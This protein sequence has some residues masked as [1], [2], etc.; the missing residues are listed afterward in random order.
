MKNGTT[1]KNKLLNLLKSSSIEY[2]KIVMEMFEANEK[3]IYPLDFFLLGIIK[4]SISLMSG[5]LL[6]MKNDNYLSA[7]PLVRLH[8]DNLLQ[9]YA[10]F[11][12]KD[13]HDIAT[14]IMRGKKR[15]REYY[16]KD[17]KKMSDNYLAKKFFSNKKNEEFIGLENVYNEASKFIHFSE[18]HIF[19]IISSIDSGRKNV[20][21]V[22]SD[23]VKI[24]IEKELEIIRCMIEI[25]KAQ[26]KYLIG[27][28]ETKK[29]NK[30]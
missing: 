6:L 24:P 30:C 9:I 2:D 12:V 19:S 23:E 3:N 27:W 26:F 17:G 22:I 25:T 7:T 8:I 10:M 4:R 18:K 5:F 14:N 15:I 11:I 20:R 21:I 29:Y 1:Q 16:D 28:V 13:P